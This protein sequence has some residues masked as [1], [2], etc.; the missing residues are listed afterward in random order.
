MAVKMPA[1]TID[2]RSGNTGPILLQRRQRPRRLDFLYV[3]AA[4]ILAGEAGLAIPFTSGNVSPFWPAAGVAL[5]AILLFGYRIW[6]AVALGALIANFFTAVPHITALG[7]ALGNAVG[8]LCGAWLLWRLH[9]FQPS[10]T[11]LRDVLGLSILGAFAGPAVSATIGTSVLFLTGVNAW[12]SFASTWRVWWLGDAMGVLIIT[13]LVVTF[14]QLKAIKAHR[15]LEFALLLAGTVGSALLMLDP[16]LGLL[17]ADVFA[18]GVFPFVLWAAIEF[19]AAGAA[20]VTFVISAIAEWGTAH[21]AGPFIRGN[22]LQSATLLQGFLGVTA[23]SGMVLAAVIA[24]RAQLIREQSAREALERSEKSYRGIVETAG[25]GIWKVDADFVTSFVN[26]RMAE[27]LGY[28]VEEMTGRPLLD[29][30]FD[31]DIKQKWSQLTRRRRGIREQLVTRY[32]KK[33]GS[34]IWARVAASPLLDEGGTFEGM[35]AMVSDLTELRHAE[36]EGGRL[37]DRISLLSRA[38]EQTADVVLLTD[39]HGTIEYVNPAFEATTGYSPEEAAGN[40][41]RM[42]ESPLHSLEFYDRLWDRILEGR[43]FRETFVS[44][45][46]SG[47]LY[48]TEQSISPIKDSSGCIT[49]FVFVLKD[50]TELRKQEEQQLQFRMAQEVQQ[51]FYTGAAISVPGFDIASAAHP[52]LETGGDYL[53]L[54]CMADNRICIGIG[55]ISGHGLDT[56]LVMALTRAY[57]RSFAE[58]EE[59]LAKILSRVNHMLVADRLE[60]GRFVTVLLVS[61][62]GDHHSLCYSSAG[63]FPGFLISCSGKVDSVLESSGP[64]L[65]LF[66]D[67]HFVTCNLPLGP[68][69][70]V[71]LTTDGA[72]EMAASEEA[73]EEKEFGIDGILEY[74]RKHLRDSAGDLAEGIYRSARTFAG[75]EPQHDDA[76][77]VIIKVA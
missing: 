51:R 72:A 34:A 77:N 8:P 14:G 37:R 56:A 70:M 19:D 18:F 11:R 25:E 4:C 62:D 53:D 67:A 52:A 65:G 1:A 66:D 64:P 44:R 35:L 75:S 31:D 17:R 28:T 60:H 2:S 41:P 57:I 29:F 30:L 32:R 10:L 21:G 55:D 13:P 73:S 26:R 27:L 61:L 63:H 3:L 22:P 46:K 6:P 74:V 36:V 9:G 20:L 33:D 42:L 48:L 7:L 76:T 12:S 5:A 58:V 54:F 16:R 49:N 45:K 43:A 15:R 39:R 24:E 59:D 68:Q 40:T 23:L 50:V 38:V 69:Q 71:V 47:Q